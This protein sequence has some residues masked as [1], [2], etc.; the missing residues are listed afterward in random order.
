MKITKIFFNI[1]MLF[2]C[3]AL[4]A[5]TRNTKEMEKRILAHDSSFGEVL[6]LRDSL[7]KELDLKRTDFSNKKNE[8]DEEISRVRSRQN[9]E[10][11][12][13][14]SSA[15]GVKKQMLP[16][17]GK[18]REDLLKTQQIRDEQRKKVQ[19]IGKDIAEVNSLLRKKDVLGLGRDE[20][21]T[22][23][24]RLASLIEKKAI[25]ISE[26]NKVKEEIEI[27]KLKLEVLNLK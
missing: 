11:E 27:I 23:N 18:L 3:V 19:V 26:N 16:E 10:K 14:F 17:K 25:L 5:C 13:Y 24:D 2:L 7:Q 12:K 6:K 4:Q 9:Q 15:E 8:L 22:W 20:V 1:G 21:R